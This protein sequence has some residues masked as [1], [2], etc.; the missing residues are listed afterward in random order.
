[1]LDPGSLSRERHGRQVKGPRRLVGLRKMLGLGRDLL[2]GGP[3]E[4]IE[5]P[6]RLALV[7]EPGAEPGT[8]EPSQSAEIHAARR[9]RREYRLRVVVPRHAH[10][11]DPSPPQRRPER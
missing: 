9:Q 10:Y 8:I 1:M 2:V 6:T 5:D 3:A 11:P 4:L 7:E